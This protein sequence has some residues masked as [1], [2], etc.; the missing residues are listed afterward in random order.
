MLIDN[1]FGGLLGLAVV[2]SEQYGKLS[3]VGAMVLTRGLHQEEFASGRPRE[4][5]VRKL[6]QS[7]KLQREQSARLR[8]GDESGDLADILRYQLRGSFAN[9]AERLR[10]AGIRSGDDYRNWPKL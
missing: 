6:G 4:F 10:I 2:L 7:R 8:D 5:T 1:S 9:L 3:P